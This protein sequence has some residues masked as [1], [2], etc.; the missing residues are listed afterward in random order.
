[1]DIASLF[2]WIGGYRNIGMHL[3][4]RRR[5][6]VVGEDRFGNRYF[7]DRKG[8]DMPFLG[9]RERRWVMYA[10]APDGSA[11][12]PAWHAWL[13]HTVR[14]LPDDSPVPDRSWQQDHVPNRTG[15]DA[16]YRPPGHTLAGNRRDKATG[17]YEPWVPQ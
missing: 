12:P 17:D 5:G 10:G 16:A 6:E 14:E 2:R 13:H 1:M 8:G 9:R 15:S 11:V 3:F 7:R 4:T